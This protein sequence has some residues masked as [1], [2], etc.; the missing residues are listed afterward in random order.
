MVTGKIQ[1]RK[2]KKE[3]RKK[4]GFDLIKKWKK[5]RKY[6]LFFQ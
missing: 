1:I 5:F 4:A 3:K 6:P 2:K